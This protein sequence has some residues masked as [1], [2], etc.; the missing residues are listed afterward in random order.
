MKD[1][2]FALCGAFIAMSQS[3]FKFIL[4]KADVFE[5][6][7]GFCSILSKEEKDEFYFCWLVGII[8]RCCV[9]FICRQYLQV[10]K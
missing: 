3:A 5:G 2:N 6:R 1:V 7:I 4:P 8:I 9:A 10:F